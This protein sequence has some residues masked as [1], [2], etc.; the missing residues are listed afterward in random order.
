MSVGILHGFAVEK[1]TNS[2]TACNCSDR[3]FRSASRSWQLS[4]TSRMLWHRLTVAFLYTST[5]RDIAARYRVTVESVVSINYTALRKQLKTEDL[6]R[7]FGAASLQQTLT[8]LV[9]GFQLAS[10][11]LHLQAEVRWGFLIALGSALSFLGI[12]LIQAPLPPVLRGEKQSQPWSCLLVTD[13]LRSLMS[14]V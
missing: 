6:R 14:K 3:P 7:L 12:I 9:S 8:I 11:S 13:A 10:E 1:K 2:P 5:A 4:M